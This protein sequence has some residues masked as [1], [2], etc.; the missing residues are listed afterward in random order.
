[1]TFTASKIAVRVI[2]VRSIFF[3]LHH[4]SKINLIADRNGHIDNQSIRK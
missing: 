4:P 3:T 2:V 1:M